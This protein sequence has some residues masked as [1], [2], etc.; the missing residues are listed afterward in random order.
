MLVLLWCSE[1]LGPVVQSIVSL[2][3]SLSI[4]QLNY[5]IHCY[6]LLKKKESFALQKILIFFSTKIKVYL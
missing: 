4:C 6:F 2:S 3:T 1:Y 5:Q